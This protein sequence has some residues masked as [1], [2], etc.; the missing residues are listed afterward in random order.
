[1]NWFL[2]G[3]TIS[4]HNSKAIYSSDTLLELQALIV[5][6]MNQLIDCIVIG[7][8]AIHTRVIGI[9]GGC[10][11][12]PMCLIPFTIH[13]E[14]RYNKYPCLLSKSIILNII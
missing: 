10:G 11:C 12:L 13:D 8:R 5:S 1:M 9:A 2:C 3:Q 6:S 14:F 7:W 4:L